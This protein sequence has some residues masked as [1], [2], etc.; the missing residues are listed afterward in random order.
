MSK[1]FYQRYG[2]KKVL[3]EMLLYFH[4]LILTILFSTKFLE[5]S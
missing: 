4:N 3:K 1:G 5:F 2:N